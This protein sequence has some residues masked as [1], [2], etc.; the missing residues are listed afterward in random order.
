MM[1]ISRRTFCKL[2]GVSATAAALYKS[3]G[4]VL[5]ALNLIDK[6]T[7]PGKEAWVPSVCQL[8]P[9]ECGLLVRVVGGLAVKI[10]GNPRNP[11]NQGRTCPKG[12]VSPQLLY[13][14]DRLRTPLKRIGERGE[15]HWQSISWNEAIES[16]AAR[17][18]DLRLAGTPEH[19][20]FLY[21]RPPGLL[22]ETI[23]YFCR[24]MGT[25][26]AIDVHPSALSQALL[27]TQG[28]AADPAYDLGD[29][30][31]LLSFNYA[32]LESAQPTVH[33]LGAYS[34]M[35]RGRPGDRGRIVQ[36][37][38]R[39]SVTAIK[40][41]Q[42]VPIRPGTEGALALGL[43]SVIIRE[44][45]YDQA[46]VADHCHGFEAWSEAVLRDYS[47][48]AVA[49]LTGVPEEMIRQLAREFAGTKP[50]VAVGGEAVSQQSNGLVSQMA[51][52]CLNALVGSI[53]VP[54]GVLMQRPPPLTPW[55]DIAADN[56]TTQGLAQP[57]LDSPERYLLGR[58]LAHRLP[59]VI[60][61]GVPYP[62]EA[63]L[64]YR[65][66]PLHDAPEPEVWREALKKVPLIVSFDSFI[67]E[68]SAY[69][70]YILPDH[71]FLERW[72]AAPVLPSL[73]YPMLAVGQPAVEPLYDTRALDDVLIQLAHQVGGQPAASFPWTDYL[74]LLRFRIG[75]LMDSGRGSIN[76]ATADDFWSELAAR[77]VW[78][79]S[80]YPY[81][82]GDKG[83][84]KQWEIV[85]ATPSGKFEFTPQVLVEQA[86]LSPPYYEPPRY[87]GAEGEYPFHL[88]LYTLM[89]QA[90]GP[91]GANLPHLHELYG[92]HIKQMWGNWV[93]INPE[94]AQKL[95]IA[96]RDE[97]WVESPVG[98]IRLP[99][100]LYAG[101]QPDVVS[102]PAGLGH[103]LGGQWSAGIGANPEVLV[104]GQQA[105]E[106][107]GLV[108]R[109][110]MRVKVYKAETGA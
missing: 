67:E 75:G 27:L 47:P 89:A 9:A 24:A 34:F 7:P 71:T 41:D 60:L 39:L 57:R 5:A 81:A 38:P 72:S 20:A 32:L 101:A 40:A 77:G 29:C 65:A 52:H 59:E 16:V 55:P 33:L 105:D 61:S 62:L 83:D 66:N 31:Y 45:L 49:V 25:P 108:A 50:A 109:Q 86:S 82:G 46:F 110:G 30:R 35:H 95:G 100:R 3:T 63:L 28:W 85:L 19:L 107:S 58:A 44:R 15:G 18:R 4:S 23:N 103:T 70:D 74:E 43:A 76:T 53:D 96:D 94:V 11:N 14:P 102:I 87:V 98:R 1:Q 36:I 90:I 26:N 56:V 79:D 88:Q 17:L 80:P 64:L 84:A 106:L 69:A 73:G 21:D 48:S 99:A 12:Q 51:I 91:G 93:E 13:N 6:T 97:V 104:S 68:T 22:G 78:V 92:L 42:W 10:E 37:E 54:G 8:C 2:A